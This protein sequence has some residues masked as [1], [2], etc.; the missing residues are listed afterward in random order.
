MIVLERFEKLRTRLTGGVITGSHT[1]VA[2]LS[3]AWRSRTNGS[4]KT[5]PC[6]ATSPFGKWKQ[7]LLTWTEIRIDSSSKF[8]RS[9]LPVLEPFRT[10][11]PRPRPLIERAY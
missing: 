6:K 11:F 1:L 7:G 9:S 8:S 2:L 5:K 3:S 10:P 4:D